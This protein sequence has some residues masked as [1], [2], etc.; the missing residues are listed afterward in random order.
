MRVLRWDTEDLAVR[1]RFAFWYDTM[2]R[3]LVH[4]W[5]ATDHP[6]RFAASACVFD[7]GAVQLT[8]MSHHRLLAQRPARL[9]RQSDPEVFQLHLVLV[10]AGGLAQAGRDA[11]FQAGQLLLIDSSR[12]YEGWRGSADEPAT[13]LVVQFP[14]AAL[15]LRSDMVGQLTATPIPVRHGITGVLAGHLKHLA[16]NADGLTSRDAQT[17]AAVTLDLIAATFG[18]RLEATALLSPESR[19]QALLSLIHDFVRKRLGDPGLTPA[20]IAA[21]HQ[22]SVRHLYK[23]FEE[24]GVT[25]AA[26]IR[27]CRLEQCHRDLADPR[28]RSRQIQDIATRWGFADAATFSRA[29]RAAY[30]MS[31][32]DHRRLTA[33]D[34]PSEDAPP[35]P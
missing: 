30:G 11:A 21:A 20:T 14:R 12:P 24:Q 16:D 23:L 6:A 29:F 3:A 17:V 1:D 5:L 19:R 22:I 28:Q 10:G 15:G 8:T 31:P 32:R 26:W 4:S 9:I 27:R 25:V 33:G 18:D 35:R 34:G 2:S 7:L 13:S